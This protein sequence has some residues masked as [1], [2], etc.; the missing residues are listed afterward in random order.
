MPFARI[1]P[2]ML[3]APRNKRHLWCDASYLL[4]HWNL[5]MRGLMEAAK[6]ASLLANLRSSRRSPLPA[7]TCMKGV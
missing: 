4:S 1:M 5:D 2:G 7:N 3:L 6:V